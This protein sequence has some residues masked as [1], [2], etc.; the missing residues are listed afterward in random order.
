MEISSQEEIE[1]KN[2]L[3]ESFANNVGLD[4]GIFILL[5]LNQSSHMSRVNL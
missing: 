3:N 4:V 5:D 2:H 1:K